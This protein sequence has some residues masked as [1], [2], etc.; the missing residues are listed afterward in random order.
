MPAVAEHWP[1]A[2][3]IPATAKHVIF[4]DRPLAADSFHD[5]PSQP[6]QC[7]VGDQEIYLYPPDGIGRSRLAELV[8]RRLAD[9][10]AT[11][12]NWNTVTRLRD[13]ASERSSS[14]SPV[15]SE[16]AHWCLT[17]VVRIA[18]ALPGLAGALLP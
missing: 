12:R 13:L 16:V 15:R 18:M 17:S 5:L 6:E 3:D 10:T 7:A 9:Y 4:L 2:A 1:F 11:T 8:A 14:E